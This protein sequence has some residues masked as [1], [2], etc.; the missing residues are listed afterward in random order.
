MLEDEQIEF[1]LSAIV[2]SRFKPDLE[3][4]TYLNK[5]GSAI[6]G[7]LSRTSEDEEISSG[8]RALI[9]KSFKVGAKQKNNFIACIC[10]SGL[11]KIT[12]KVSYLKKATQIL[13]SSHGED[14][15]VSIGNLTALNEMLSTDDM[16]EKSNHKKYINAALFDAM[17]ANISPRY[18]A[19]LT[20][21]GQSLD[22]A[23]NEPQVGRI[24]IITSQ[25][26]DP[27][28]SATLDV[29]TLAEK[30]KVELNQEVL[31][32]NT[33]DHR[34]T[35]SG[36]MIPSQLYT[37]HKHYSD[38]DDITN[39]DHNYFFH[40]PAHSFDIESNIV[41]CVKAITNF[42]PSAIVSY[43]SPDML[44]EVFTDI[45]PVISACDIDQDV[46]MVDIKSHC[47]DKDIGVDTEQFATAS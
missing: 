15:T 45:V 12:G 38:A 17:N 25:F 37:V 29:L 33:Y 42:A 11:Y 16:D 26:I 40:Q 39:N 36:C 31:I 41:S 7:I 19:A 14:L 43:R 2:D 28:D 46:L 6:V 35:N 1:F 4:K 21:A 30:I 32:V 22:M 34:D 20:T 5:F 8:D 9:M 3:D 47:S 24:A 27:D 23:T 10:N 18:Q 13:R 44:G